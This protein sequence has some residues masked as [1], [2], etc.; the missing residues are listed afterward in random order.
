MRWPSSVRT[1]MFCRFGL[2]EESRPVAATAWLKRV[3]MRPSAPTSSGRA[4]M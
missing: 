1:G 2:V 3:W 4:S